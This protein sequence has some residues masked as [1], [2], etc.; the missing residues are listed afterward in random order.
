M[1]GGEEVHRKLTLMEAVA[2]E[3]AAIARGCPTP[4]SD[5]ERPSLFTFNKLSRS[6][7]SPKATYE[8][9]PWEALLSKDEED[10]LAREGKLPI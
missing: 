8:I 9:I 4:G 7:Q 1:A 5:R 2:M 6:L 10:R 3:N